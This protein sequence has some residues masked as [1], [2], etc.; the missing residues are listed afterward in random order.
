MTKEKL[1]KGW[2]TAIAIILILQCIILIFLINPLEKEEE[3]YTYRTQLIE[4]DN[5]NFYEK[6]DVIEYICDEGVYVEIS[7]SR[8]SFYASTWEKD[9]G[10]PSG[11]Y[12]KC[13]I[14]IREKLLR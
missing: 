13:F 2:K 10:N 6:I 9:D 14:K 12:G 4:L 3:K 7:D 8:P 5:T 1:N 11:S